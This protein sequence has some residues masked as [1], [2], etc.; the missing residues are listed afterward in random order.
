MAWKVKWPS[1]TLD[2]ARDLF[3]SERD[4]G[5]T[6]RRGRKKAYTETRIN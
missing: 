4:T 6:T 1:P 2:A 3:R 5:I